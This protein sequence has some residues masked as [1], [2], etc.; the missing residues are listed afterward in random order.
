MN[1]LRD[2]WNQ[3][4]RNELPAYA[5]LTRAHI[6]W[7]HCCARII[8]DNVFGGYWREYILAP[9]NKHMTAEQLTKAI[10][11]SERVLSGQVSLNFLDR[12]SLIWR[13]IAKERARQDASR[14]SSVTDPVE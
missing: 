8:L 3:L 1:E 6:K 10:E 9:A 13:G 14:L 4:W 7:D 5:R 12:Q 11:L 2:R